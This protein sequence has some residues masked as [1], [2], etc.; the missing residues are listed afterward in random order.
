MRSNDLVLDYTLWHL[1][2]AIR[3]SGSLLMAIRF[4]Y[5]GKQY[6]VDTP[7][8]VI[9]LQKVLQAHEARE[10]G[11]EQQM[12]GDS[13][14]TPD[15]FSGFMDRI[16]PQQ[17]KA[18]RA[19]FDHHSLLADELAKRIAVDEGSL[20]GVLSGLSKQL[21]ALGLTPIDLYQVHTDWSDGQRRRTFILQTAFRLAA[22]EAGWQEERNLHAT[23]T[24]KSRK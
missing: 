6:E 19:M 21:K 11:L 4:S 13:A 7:E 8:E 1:Y 22:E 16:G 20:G 14:W 18:V 17:K 9:R 2:S 15:V 23:S 10:S 5:R 12:R 3:N 24:S